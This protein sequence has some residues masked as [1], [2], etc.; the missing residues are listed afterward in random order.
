MSRDGEKEI[1]LTMIAS[2][3]FAYKMATLM[4]EKEDIYASAYKI[5]IISTFCSILRELT[6]EMPELDYGKLVLRGDNLLESLYS[7]WLGVDD[8]I[9]LDMKHFVIGELKKELKRSI[10]SEKRNDKAA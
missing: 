4:R 2:E 10:L 1:F 3:R 9:Y 5:M 8:G 7:I 6:V